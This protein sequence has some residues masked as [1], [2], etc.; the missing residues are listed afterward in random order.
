MKAGR[1]AGRIL[2]TRPTRQGSLTQTRTRFVAA[3]QPPREPAPGAKVGLNVR[4]TGLPPRMRTM[5]QL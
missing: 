4:V 3:R 5:E 1:L 2:R